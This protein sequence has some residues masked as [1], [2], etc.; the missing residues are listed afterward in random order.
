M[1]IE[2]R[3]A[4]GTFGVL[5]ATWLNRRIGNSTVQISWHGSIGWRPSTIISARR[6]SGASHPGNAEAGLRVA[7]GARL[8]LGS[9]QPLPG[10]AQL[11]RAYL[12]PAGSQHATL[13]LT[14]GCSTTWGDTAGRWATWRMRVP[15]WRKARR[16]WAELGAEG[17]EGTGRGTELVGDGCAG[18]R[19]SPEAAEACF[20][21]QLPALPKT[22]QPAASQ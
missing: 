12:L 2:V 17:D 14:P 20:V 4:R 13:R 10:D 1:G 11:V 7:G 6:W 21:A 19:A 18:R 22:W 9:A 16:I 15:C 3:A 8:A 5:P